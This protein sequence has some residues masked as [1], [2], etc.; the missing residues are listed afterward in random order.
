MTTQIDVY[1][2][3]VCPFCFL[4]ENDGCATGRRHH[5]ALRLPATAD[6]TSP[7]PVKDGNTPFTRYLEIN[8]LSST[9]TA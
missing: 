4:V 2:D 1:L 9:A 6:F 7:L 8:R 3:Y 5:P